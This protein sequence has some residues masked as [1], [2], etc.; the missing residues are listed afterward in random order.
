VKETDFSR[1]LMVQGLLDSRSAVVLGRMQSPAG[2]GLCLACINGNTLRIY[3]TDYTQR[4]GTLF[5]EIPLRE[6][7]I[8][9]SSSFVLNSFLK[10]DWCG[11]QYLLKDFTQAKEF[12][13]IVREENKK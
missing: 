10:F 3:E 13:A 9:K 8:V 5:H 4:L 11:D 7:T 6:I 12:L 1:K 2:Y